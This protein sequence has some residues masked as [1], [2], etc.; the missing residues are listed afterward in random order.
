[1]SADE[2]K[3]TLEITAYDNTGV[4][5]RIAQVFA[6]RGHSIETLN[7]ERSDKPG[8]LPKLYITAYGKKARFEQIVAQI[9]K[10]I[11]IQNVQLKEEA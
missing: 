8:E 2:H 10:L 7:V 9:R 3:F 6:R 5:V 4:I 1:M 11:D